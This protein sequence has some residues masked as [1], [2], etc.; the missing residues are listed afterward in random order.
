[1]ALGGFCMGGAAIGGSS[2]YEVVSLVQIVA[3]D[4]GP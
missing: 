3:R 2:N 4:R 1:M